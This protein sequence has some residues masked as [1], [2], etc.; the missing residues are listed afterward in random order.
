VSNARSHPETLAFDIATDLQL[1]ISWED[2]QN[3]M[4]WPT[5]FS[6]ISTIVF[7]N[8][9]KLIFIAEHLQRKQLI[10]AA[11]AACQNVFSSIEVPTSAGFSSTRAGS[12]D[13]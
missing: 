5:R 10:A 7:L 2:L 6:A 4:I 8:Q 1:T 3:P 9:L 11:F 12:S 13:F